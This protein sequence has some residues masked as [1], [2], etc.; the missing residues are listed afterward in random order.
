[1]SCFGRHQRK[2]EKTCKQRIHTLIID[3]VSIEEIAAINEFLKERR[4]N[5]P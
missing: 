2:H 5:E 3:Y 4:K 1:M